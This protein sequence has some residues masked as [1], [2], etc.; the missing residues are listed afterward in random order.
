MEWLKSCGV[1]AVVLLAGCR[2]SGDPVS[3]LEPVVLPE[4]CEYSF[5][6]RSDSEALY[7]FD[8]PTVNIALPF[9][10]Q[11]GEMSLELSLEIDS[12]L[13]PD[14]LLELKESV[15]Y[16]E[17]YAVDGVR[18]FSGTTNGSGVLDFVKLTAWLDR[19]GCVE[20]QGVVVHNEEAF[21]FDSVNEST[22]VNRRI[23]EN[24]TTVAPGAIAPSFL[25]TL[26]YTVMIDHSVAADSGLTRAF[27]LPLALLHT[28][29]GFLETQLGV[30]GR[31]DR[32]Q[33]RVGF[34]NVLEGE[35]PLVQLE[36]TASL[37]ESEFD[38]SLG[39]ISYFFTSDRPALSTSFGG[40]GVGVSCDA[41][42]RTILSY[43]LS[44]Y[45]T[46]GAVTGTEAR[47]THA[48][49]A[50]SLV[51]LFGQWLGEFT[52]VASCASGLNQAQGFLCPTLPTFPYLTGPAPY[53]KDQATLRGRLEAKAPA[54][55]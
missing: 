32:V 34:S 11:N 38:D 9:E 48:N 44:E 40:S 15:F 30:N 1:L 31:V 47:P 35:D 18:F 13:K 26:D 24:G 39:D 42:R 16:P 10:S 20:L 50:V 33:V 3:L 25:G 14:A 27:V 45:Q 41:D 46:L 36:E 23:W 53:F 22:S 6:T 12:I 4:T 51:R 28:Q 29:N 54:C 55:F 2:G 49:A 37:I 52:D 8:S 5:L 43:G 17:P 21:D 7:N 19:E